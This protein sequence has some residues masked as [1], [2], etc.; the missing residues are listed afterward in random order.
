MPLFCPHRSIASQNVYLNHKSGSVTFQLKTFLGSM[1]S[2]RQIQ[3]LLEW[4]IKHCGL[5]PWR[6]SPALSPPTLCSSGTK[7]HKTYC[8]YSPCL[9]PCCPLCLEC[10]SVSLNLATPASSVRLNVGSSP[11][12][13]PSWFPRLDEVLHSLTH[14]AS[15]SHCT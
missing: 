11:R 15:L 3:S 6:D 5:I 14:C 13:S 7:L 4:H 10:S 8:F 9:D 2:I 12:G 1:L